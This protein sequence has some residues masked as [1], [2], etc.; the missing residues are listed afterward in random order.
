[1]WPERR[2]RVQDVVPFVAHATEGVRSV[3][4]VCDAKRE[5]VKEQLD[6]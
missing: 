1:M 5:D 2:D 3:G 4:V 6:G